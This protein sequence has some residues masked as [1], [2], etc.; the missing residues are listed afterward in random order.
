LFFADAPP[1][2]GG[3]MARKVQDQPIISMEEAEKVLKPEQME[4]VRK[5]EEYALSTVDP[6]DVADTFSRSYDLK[7]RKWFCCRWIYFWKYRICVCWCWN[8][9]WW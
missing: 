8:W 9:W 7:Y 6:Y 1:E 2:E 5:Y 3:S 4:V